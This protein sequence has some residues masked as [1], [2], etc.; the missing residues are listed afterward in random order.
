MKAKTE[1]IHARVDPE[2]KKN[3]ERIFQDVGLTSTQAIRLF[4]RQ[5]EM[6]NG[7]PFAVEIPNDETVATMRK[8]DAGEDIHRARDMADLLKKLGI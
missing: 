3:V 4:Y 8:T 1:M 7:L 6:R 5:V 2:L